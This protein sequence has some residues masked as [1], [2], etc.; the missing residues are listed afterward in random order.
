MFFNGSNPIAIPPNTMEQVQEI[1]EDPFARCTWVIPIRGTLPWPDCSSA[2]ILREGMPSSVGSRGAQLKPDP[3]IASTT[4][5]DVV[6]TRAAV[7]AFWQFLVDLRKSENLGPIALSFH[8]VTSRSGTKTTALANNAPTANTGPK[9]QKR[10]VAPGLLDC[11]H[12]KIYHDARYAMHLRNVFH[13][14]SYQYSEDSTGTGH[15]RPTA[16]L[17]DNVAVD[18]EHDSNVKIK[19]R[20]LKNVRLVL[21]DEVS[22]AILVC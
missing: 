17:D 20:L 18:V 10:K 11:D 6:W 5:S 2:V 7:R 22:E 13:A 8:A 15:E 19:V 4:T 12:F 14:W 3:E 1:L 21:L 9:S 16:S